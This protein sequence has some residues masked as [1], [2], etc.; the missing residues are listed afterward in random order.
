MPKA[1]HRTLV[2]WELDQLE[3]EHKVLRRKDVVE[4][5]R[6]NPKSALFKEFEWD[7]SRAGELFRIEVAG[8]LIKVHVT[9][10]S[11]PDNVKD[12]KISTFQSLPKE[13]SDP[14]GGYRRITAI[15]NKEPDRMELLRY[16]IQRLRSVKEV[17]I[18]AEL[19]EV[20]KEIDA[21][22]AKYL[23]DAA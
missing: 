11:S 12:V 22:A 7:D 14:Q 9:V 6:N 8:R 10:L 15:I 17:W 23:K 18:F 2:Q 4:F 16:T 13:R 3:K 5:A 19:A 21:V 1:S 20:A